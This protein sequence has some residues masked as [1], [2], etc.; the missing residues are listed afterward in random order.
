M[1]VMHSLLPPILL[2]HKQGYLWAKNEW[3]YKWMG[4]LSKKPLGQRAVAVRRRWRG[5][6]DGPFLNTH[7]VWSLLG[8]NPMKKA[9]PQ[10]H[11]GIPLFWSLPKT[12]S[13][14]CPTTTSSSLYK[15]EA[16]Q[17]KTRGNAFLSSLLKHR[18]CKWH[19]PTVLWHTKV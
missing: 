18:V 11:L 12:I 16:G 13:P 17:V 6:G 3:I 5:E 1:Y 15:N 7:T 8:F 19:I 2:E 4:V 14:P 9:K 10:S